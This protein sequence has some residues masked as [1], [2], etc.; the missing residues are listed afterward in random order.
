MASSGMLR[1]VTLVITEVSEEHN[2]SFIKVTRI[3]ELGTTPAVTSNRRT[4][5]RNTWRIIPEYA[6][7]WIYILLEIVKEGMSTE[8]SLENL[9]KNPT[10]NSE[11]AMKDTIT[12]YLTGYSFYFSLCPPFHHCCTYFPPP[13]KV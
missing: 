4:L 8:F 11:D 13:S 3:G 5:R 6:V 1:H 2:A 7:L 10:F 12:K 9:C